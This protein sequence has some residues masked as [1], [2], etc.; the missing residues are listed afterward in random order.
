DAV[1]AFETKDGMRTDGEVSDR[2]LQRLSLALA[3]RKA[4]V[5]PPAVHRVAGTGF[6]VSRSGYVLTALHL[7]DGCPDIRVRTLGSGGATTPGV[8]TDPEDDR[9]LLRLKAP[10]NAAVTFHDGRGPRAG[11]GIVVSGL[12]L[13]DGGSSD[14]Y[15]TAGTIAAASGG[16]PSGQRSELGVIKI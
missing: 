12:T 7:V 3:I 5:A 11:D 1:K 14:F 6:V 10:A 4:I 9:A 15:L 16:V 13:G 8:G 2:L